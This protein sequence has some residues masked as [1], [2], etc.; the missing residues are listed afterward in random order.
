MPGSP[1]TPANYLTAPYNTTTQNVIYAYPYQQYADDP[2]VAAFFTAYTAYAQGYLNYLNNLSLPVYTGGIIHGPLLD[3]VGAGI[4]GMIR[5]SLPIAG[6]RDRGAFNTFRFNP[7]GPTSGVTFNGYVKGI[8]SGSIAT[9]DDVY[10]RVL[11]WAFYKGDGMQFT[12]TWLKRRIWRFL[13]GA[14]GTAPPVTNTYSIS[15][16][17]T[18]AYAATIT[19]PTGTLGTTFQAAV[20]GGMLELPFKITWTVVLT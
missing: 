19:I 17:F 3:W 6:T 12:I 16:K 18:S 8:P 7:V 4:Y 14:N 15:V 1:Q 10:K 13:N 9:T 20:N 5:P 2:N 11:T